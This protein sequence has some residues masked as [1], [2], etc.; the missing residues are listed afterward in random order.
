MA[1]ADN[2]TPL[3]VLE[4]V[5]IDTETT[6]LDPRKAWTVELAA[7]RISAGRVVPEPVFRRLV[8]PPEPIPRAAAAIHGI[9]DGMVAAAPAFAEAWPDYAAFM[10]TGAVVIGHAVG[11]DLAVLRRECERAGLP[12]TRP[13]TLDTL[14]LA[15]VAQPDL[16][17]YS[18]DSLA[19]WLGITIEGRH[20]GLGDARACAQLFLALVPRLRARGIR[21]LAE[22]EQACRTLTEVLDQHHRAGWVEPVSAPVRSDREAV[23]A[24]IDSYPYRHTI[25]EIMRA[26]PRLAASDTPLSAALGT[27]VGERI[28]SLFVH[29]PGADPARLRPAD[30]GI[31]TE[32]DI[33]RAL[34]HHGPDAFALPVAKVMAKPLAAVPADAFVYRAIGRMGRLGVRHLAAV[35]EAGFVVGALSA[36]DLLRLRAGEAVTLGD[37]IDQ[38]EDVEGLA[39]AWATLPRVAA[40]LSA[41]KVSARNVAAVI[42]REL[43]AV[44]RQAAVIAEARM[45]DAG[46]GEPPCA[47]AVAVLGSAGRGESLLAMDQDNALF[48]AT[49]DPDGPEDRWFAE[50]GTH[51]AAILN[52]VGLPFCK[53]GVMGKTP[54]WRGSVATWRERIAAWVRRSRPQDLLSVDI[55]FDLRPVH[56]DPAIANDLR[57]AAFDAAKGEIAFAKLLAESAGAVELGLGFFGGFRTQ[58]G[59]LDLKRTG[60]FPIVTAAR[61]LAIRHHVVERSTPERLAAMRTLG[62]GGQHDLQGLVDALG[63]FLDLILAQQLADLEHGIPAGNAVVVKQL[64]QRDRERL[65]LGLEQVAQ[66]DWLTRD[67]LI[68]R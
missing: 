5:A 6:G 43:G 39:A 44:T 49:G 59:R 66:I 8:R 10:R 21:T 33:L 2:A 62:L 3:M 35:D 28:S 4:A 9:D 11:F 45:R 61:A 22:A 52:D 31:V 18:L 14:L 56:G 64:A 63:T 57:A 42:S 24:R 47:Y 16:A 48:F 30:L 38:A 46:R 1:A 68:G 26:P 41:E 60:T 40:A 58:G 53:G 34:A 25:G 50:L 51:L 54:E 36:R 27:L 37:A 23:F 13:R 15:E 65:R 17:E 67:L 32:R 7:V 29:A 20:S 12:W 55:F 19:S